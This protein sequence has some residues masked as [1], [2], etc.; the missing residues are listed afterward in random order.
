MSFEGK[1]CV[2]SLFPIRKIIVRL[3]S[4][5]FLSIYLGISLYRIIY[6]EDISKKLAPLEIT[7]VKIKQTSHRIRKYKQHARTTKL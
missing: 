1:M 4:N 6:N 2:D 7:E 5:Y 3:L